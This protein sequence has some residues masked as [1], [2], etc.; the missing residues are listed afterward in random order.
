MLGLFVTICATVL[1]YRGATGNLP[2]RVGQRLHRAH[3]GAQAARGTT[4]TWGTQKAPCLRDY[5]SNGRTAQRAFHLKTRTLE[6][7]PYVHSG[8]RRQR[9]TPAVSS[10]LS[11]SRPFAM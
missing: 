11:L 6:F 7:G 8:C 5:N 1:P 3:T 10:P 9:P 2:A 4:N